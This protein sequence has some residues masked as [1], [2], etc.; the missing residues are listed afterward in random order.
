MVP[1]LSST[2]AHVNKDRRAGRK[3]SRTRVNSLA[4]IVLDSNHHPCDLCRPAR[5]ATQPAKIVVYEQCVTENR[6][7][8]TPELTL[9][10]MW[11]QMKDVLNQTRGNRLPPHCPSIQFFIRGSVAL[12]L[13]GSLRCLCHG[14]CVCVCAACARSPGW[15]CCHS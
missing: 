4:L 11:L 7:S 12:I 10:G 2:V 5:H 6:E 15:G 14:C 8:H 3:G 9:S 1:V 13:D